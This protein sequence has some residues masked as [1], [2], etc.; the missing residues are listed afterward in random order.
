[1]TDHWI[2]KS[3]LCD[4]HSAG[5]MRSGPLIATLSLSMKTMVILMTHSVNKLCHVKA[6]I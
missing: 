6:V 2:Y 5:E 3:G 1:M 4:G